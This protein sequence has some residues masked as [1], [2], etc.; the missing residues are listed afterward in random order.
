M[1]ATT[2][3]DITDKILGKVAAKNGKSFKLWTAQLEDLLQ[4]AI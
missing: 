1:C 3:L 2:Y 4:L